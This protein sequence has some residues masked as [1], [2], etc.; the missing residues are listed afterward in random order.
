[1]FIVFCWHFK[2]LSLAL[3]FILLVLLVITM[4]FRD[5]IREGTYLG[6][7]SCKVSAGL[8]LGFL[9]FLVSEIF[10]F[11]SFF[12]AYLHGALA[13]DISL[14]CSWPPIGVCTS[15]PY[16]IPLL[17]TCLLLVSACVLTWRHQSLLLSSFS[18]CF[19]ALSLTLLLGL[20]FIVCQLYEYKILSFTI[21]DSLFGSVFYLGTGFH[22]LH[23]FVGL[24][25]LLV[26]SVRLA[27]GHFIARSHQGFIFAIWYWHFVDVIW[28]LLYIIFYIWGS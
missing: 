27:F 20:I 6:Y 23:V 4:W 8:R 2:N 3:V 24:V 9:F 26:C 10:F 28:L 17:N 1:L 14:G 15:S 22:G 5:I 16:T 12:W 18:S 13:P 21:A 25:F 11:V 19:S 7:H